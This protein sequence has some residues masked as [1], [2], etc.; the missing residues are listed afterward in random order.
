MDCKLHAHFTKMI[1]AKMAEQGE[2]FARE[3]RRFRLL[4]RLYSQAWE[5]YRVTGLRRLRK[6]VTKLQAATAKS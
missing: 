5:V 6:V 3:L 1:D 2:S 4:N